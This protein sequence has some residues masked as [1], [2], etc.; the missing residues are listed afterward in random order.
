MRILVFAAAAGLALSQEPPTIKVEVNV[1][2]ILCSVRNDKGALVSNL[3]KDDFL[4]SEEGKPQEIRY[5]ARETDLPLTLG[6]L[7]DVSGSQRNLIETER[8]TAHQFFSKV[9]RKSDLAFLISFGA[10]AELLQDLTSSLVLLRDGLDS[11]RLSTPPV[12]PTNSPV[13]TMNQT[14]G[15]V[16]Y[17]AV[18][19][20]ATE[21]LRSETGR[22]AIV[23]ITDGVDMGSRVKLERAI[24]AA[25]KADAIIYSVYYSD[26]GAYGRGPLYFSSD[27]ELK[28]MS[29][30]TGGRV[31]RVNRNN[32]LESIFSQI[33]EEMRSQYA[34]G[35][36]PPNSVKDGGYRRVDL[37][38]RQ[39]GLKVQA[40]KGYYS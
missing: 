25:Q 2:N 34:I 4:L 11:L 33:Q 27:S 38:T 22:K 3:T 15:T 10:E 36:V 5:F 14:R 16:L 39:K 23:L 1:V 12:S 20:A 9:L 28:K 7:V 6:L 31:F 35:F 26:P 32:M 8:R 29:E 17:D 30:E 13:P 21:K 19:L 37:R 24:E 18:Y 40:R